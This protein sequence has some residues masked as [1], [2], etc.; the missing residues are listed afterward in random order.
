M[1]HA[2]GTAPTPATCRHGAAGE[3]GICSGERARADARAAGVPV[4]Y[5]ALTRVLGWT[6]ASL[7]D[8]VPHLV[9]PDGDLSECGRLVPRGARTPVTAGVASTA[10]HGCW[11]SVLGET[12]RRS[13]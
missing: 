5:W 13:R 7:H 2:L 10:C 6:W 9:P 8:G 11:R 12:P 1:N 4:A 3:C